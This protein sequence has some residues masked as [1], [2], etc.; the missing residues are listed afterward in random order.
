MIF[1][2]ITMTLPYFSFDCDAAMLP[3]MTGSF[4][5]MKKEERTES[6]TWLGYLNLTVM[7]YLLQFFNIIGNPGIENLNKRGIFTCYWVLNQDA[8]AIFLA[9]KSS[10]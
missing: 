6:K 4:I 3:Y 8:E 9:L 2:T 7:I 5:D 10:I 1:G